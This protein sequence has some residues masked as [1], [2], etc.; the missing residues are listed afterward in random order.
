[1]IDEVVGQLTTLVIAMLYYCYITNI[2]HPSSVFINLNFLTISA[3]IIIPFAMF[4]FFDIAKPWIIGNIDKNIKG[5]MGVMLDDVIAGVFGGLATIPII[6]LFY[7]LN[8][9]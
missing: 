5:G 9:I 1:V 7:I 2:S 4:R 8:L 3:V 6:F